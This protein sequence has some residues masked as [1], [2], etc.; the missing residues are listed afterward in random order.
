MQVRLVSVSFY[1]AALL[2]GGF[3]CSPVWAQPISTVDLNWS[4]ATGT[5]PP[6]PWQAQF[7]PKIKAHT[8][9]ELQ[10]ATDGPSWLKIIADKSYGSWV[11]A[12]KKPGHV[13]RELSWQWRVE[14][15]PDGANLRT[16]AGDDTAVKLCLFVA[17][18]EQKLGLSQ[19]MALG[20]ARALSGED[21][22]AA[23][24]CY[25]WAEKDETAGAVFNNPYTNRVRNMVLRVLPGTATSSAFQIESRKVQ[26]DVRK[27]FGE[28]LPDGPV[29][30]LGVAVGGDADNTQSKSVGLIRAIQFKL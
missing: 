27:A 16:K 13:I 20:A 21:L 17:V 5:S 14:Q 4:S 26:D 29:R 7:H 6:I 18:D 19:R 11:Y 12:F 15:H 9:F 22:P 2:S 10:A 1:F 25:V 23:T 8:E 3:V 30:L 24:L 28:E